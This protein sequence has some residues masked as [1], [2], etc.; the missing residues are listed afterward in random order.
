MGPWAR[1]ILVEERGWLSEEEYAA[2]LGFSQILPGANTINTAVLVGDR[3]EG[4]AG[5]VIAVG[6]LLA[7]P[8][9]I[10]ILAAVLY[11]RY[12]ALPDVRGA[13]G[14]IAAAAAGLVIGTGAKMAFR[15]KPDALAL[16]LG[17]GAFFA[18]AVARV[19][20]PLTVAV[21]VPAGVAL[22][23]ARRR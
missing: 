18:V 20:L 21:L 12:G 11:D 3:F 4:L 22:G 5:S 23:F 10:L 16:V 13:L 7:A 14:G 19:P 17:A 9:A 2:A 6:A 1:R 8:M 15:L